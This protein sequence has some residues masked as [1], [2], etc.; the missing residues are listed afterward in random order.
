MKREKKSIKEIAIRIVELEKLCR[1]NSNNLVYVQ[2]MEKIISNLNF[3]ELIAIDE[4]IYQENLLT[5]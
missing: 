1:Q 5:R 3:E 4:Y 2:E